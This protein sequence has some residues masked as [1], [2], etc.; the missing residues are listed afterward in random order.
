MFDLGANGCIIMC[1]LSTDD[2][3]TYKCIAGWGE[4]SLWFNFATVEAILREGPAPKESLSDD[5]ITTSH[6]NVLHESGLARG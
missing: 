1:G 5:C 2:Y 4:A 6:T 3:V